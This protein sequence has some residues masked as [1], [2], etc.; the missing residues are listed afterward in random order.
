MTTYTRWEDIGLAIAECCKIKLCKCCCGV[1]ICGQTKLAAVE[2]AKATLID[3]TTTLLGFIASP[4]EKNWWSK[5]PNAMISNTAPGKVGPIFSLI[6]IPQLTD[7]L[8][9]GSG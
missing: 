2:R 1:D 8:T 9:I 7:K 5:L 4:T 3:T 6:G